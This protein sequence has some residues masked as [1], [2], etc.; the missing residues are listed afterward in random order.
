[1]KSIVRQL[2]N[3][4]MGIPHVFWSELE[5]TLKSYKKDVDHPLNSLPFGLI[6]SFMAPHPLPFEFSILEKSGE[7]P[8]LVS[9]E[10]ESFLKPIKGSS[11]INIHPKTTGIFFNSRSITSFFHPSKQPVTDSDCQKQK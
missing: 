3:L 5:N 9:S 2:E 7:P 8:K 10:N 6:G 4:I 11:I 1:M